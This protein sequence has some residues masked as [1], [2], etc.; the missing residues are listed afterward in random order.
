ENGKLKWAKSVGSV[1]VASLTITK[2][3]W[4]NR[5]EP[6]NLKRTAAIALPHDWLTW[7][8]KDGKDI[9]TLTTDR[10]EASGTGYFSSED[11]EY[12]RSIISMA[13]GYDFASKVVLPR[14]VGPHECIGESNIC[15]VNMK[16]GPGAGDNAAAALGLGLKPGEVVLS[17]GTS[18][19][20][21]L[22]SKVPIH[23][24]KGYV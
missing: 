17:I 8:L 3:R 20:V 12:K 21:S 24:S 4:M 9:N 10:S 6:D 14:V 23:D 16:I 1:P 5:E 11:N 7:V 13:A 22:V 15:G 19:V 18:G 2:L